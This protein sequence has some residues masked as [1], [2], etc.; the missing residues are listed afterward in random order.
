MTNAPDRADLPR[1]DMT[2]GNYWAAEII[3]YQ[4]AQGLLR[5]GGGLNA[6]QISAIE[7]GAQRAKGHLEQSASLELT[8]SGNTLKVINLT[9]HKLITGYPEGR[10]MWLII[11]WYDENN[12]LIREDGAYGPLEDKHGNP[13]MIQ[14]PS[15][16]QMVQVESIKDLHDPNT[17]IYEAHFAMTKEW[18]DVLLSVGYPA[19]LALSYDHYTG[20]PDFTL[21]DL[22][23]LTAGS[24][25][26]TFHF[27]L[28]N[29]VS[30]DNRIPPFMMDYEEARRRNALPVPA[31]QY[32]GGPGGTYNYWDEVQLNPPLAARSADIALVYQGTS[33][34]YIQFLYLA[35][36][37]RNA[38]L[39]DEGI[40]MLDA[41]LN[42]GMVPP[43]VM[44]TI[45]WEKPCQTE[46][47]YPNR[48]CYDGKDND[49]D[50][51]T[52]R[53]DRD[54]KKHY[55]RDDND[56]DISDRD[57]DSDDRGHDRKKRKSRGGKKRNNKKWKWS[58]H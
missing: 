10:R 46:G 13:V 32:G 51:F 57:S 7:A 23:A 17:K 48:T 19:D 45:K 22:A 55:G 11:K 8:G 40:N 5:L 35:N 37:G 53:K 52:D 14:N 44:E 20:S 50:G 12:I 2:G 27:V 15:T 42:T 58:R 26:K 39:G 21:G 6:A 49:C 31:D 4:D 54:C 9:G 25:H 41:W 33:W 30:M 36:N 1:H 29:H 28:N 56:S 18:A 34:E 24:Y 47:P 16:G 38:F 3:K 43:Y